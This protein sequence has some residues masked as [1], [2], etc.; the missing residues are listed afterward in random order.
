M[1]VSRPPPQQPANRLLAL[2][3]QN[4]Y[5]R[6]LPALETVPFAF[7]QVLHDAGSPIRFAYFPNRGVLSTLAVMED[8]GAIE[9]ASIGNEGLIGLSVIFG[10]ESSL[11]QV[12]CQIAG[13]GLRMEAKLLR[14]ES[15]RDGPLRELLLRYHTAFLVHVSQAAACNGLHTV[16]QRCCRWLL[17]TH[18]RV[19]DDVLPLTHEFLAIMLGVR[20]ASVSEVLE[21]LQKQGLVR[22]RR[23]QI[24][25]LDRKR[26][27]VA[28]CECYRIVAGEFQRLIG[29]RG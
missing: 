19:Q 29:I 20:R 2:L 1:S 12:I 13:D 9:V 16:Q 25:V 26:L 24:T 6:L 7:K 18:D 28:S 3:P 4:E 5:R 11:N 27:E 8:G 21:P 15:G 17:I 10:A 22:S 14:A 23:G